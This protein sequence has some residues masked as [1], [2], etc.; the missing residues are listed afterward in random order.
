M[1]NITIVGAGSDL[2]VHIDGARFGSKRII[3][4]LKF[5]FE[6]ILIEQNNSYIKSQSKYDLR[7]NEQELINYNKKLYDTIKNIDNF[8]ITIGGDHSIAISS[9]LASLRKSP[10]LG[11]IWIDAHL[12]YNTFKTTTTGNI[13]GLPLATLN[14]LNKELSIFHNNTFYNP[15]NTVVIG[16]RAHETNA[17]LELNNI[18]QMGVHVY[19]TND[20]KQKGVLNILEE[21]FKIANNNTDGLHISFDLDVIDPK[22]A[23]GV[24]VK[25]TD[26]INLE[27]TNQIIDF[28]IK[29]KNVKSIDIVEYN[30][31][32]DYN[33]QTLKIA[34]DILNK[35]INS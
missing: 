7:K 12:D 8:C 2:G 10:N 23:M 15:K 5:N 16:Y 32:N 20:I 9:G 30:P 4:N 29:Q 17:D 31:L 27:E 3:D 24:T 35:I 11:L 25:E 34:I 18:K 14:G 19:T 6:K 13:H 22:I 33:N 1:K 21:A 28:I 26:G